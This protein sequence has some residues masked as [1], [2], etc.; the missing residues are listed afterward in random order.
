VTARYLQALCCL[1]LALSAFALLAPAPASAA[2]VA[3]SQRLEQYRAWMEEARAAYPYREPIA[4]MWSVM[5]CESGGD[6]DIISPNRLYHGLF[7]YHK[8][9]W[10][11]R[12]NPYR[13]QSIF[14]PK[15]QIFATAKAWSEG[16]Q[17]WWGCYKRR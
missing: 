6:P 1:S 17:S 10:A 11:G 9:T 3:A 13:E 2:D 5:M 7:Q 14:D 16:Y 8:R 4:K 15:A 12:W